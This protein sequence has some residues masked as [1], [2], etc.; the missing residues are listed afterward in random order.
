MCF[1]LFKTSNGTASVIKELAAPINTSEK[2]DASE[3]PAGNCSGCN[4]C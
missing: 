4:H 3:S 1:F 2:P